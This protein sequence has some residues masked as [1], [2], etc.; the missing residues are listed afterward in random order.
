MAHK[1]EIHHVV[2]PIAGLIAVGVR[3]C[4]DPASLSYVTIHEVHRSDEEIDADV[5]AHIAKVE[6]LH[7]DTDHAKQHIERLIRKK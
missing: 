4:G 5:E 1:A 6:K 7:A 3:C 2:S